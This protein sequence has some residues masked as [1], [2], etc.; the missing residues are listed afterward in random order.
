MRAAR[1]W[2]SFSGA[3]RLLMVNQFGINLGFYMLMPFLADHL[4][5]GLGLAGALVGMVLGARNLS[6]Q[7]MFL[8]GGT[9]ADRLGPKPLI[10]AGCLL[11]TVGF[12]LLGLV[13]ALPALIA[14]AAA[15]GL[16]GALFN[17]AVRSYLAAESG[18]RRVEAFAAFNVFYQA[19]ILAGPVVGLALTTV[20]FRLTCLVAAA[21]FAVLTVAQLA[22]LPH[23][24]P[25]PADRRPLRDTWRH[26]LGDRAFLGFSTAMCGAYLLS[27]QTYLAL[28]LALRA[29]DPTGSR[30][31]VAVTGMFAAGGLL[32][33]LGQRRLTA[34]CTG[35]WGPGRSLVRGT[36]LLSAAFG[37][38]ALTGALLPGPAG[39]SLA[40]FVL[41]ALPLLATGLL[42]ALATMIT[43]PFEMDTIV[44]L[45]R[46]RLVAT[47]YGLYNTIA[48]LGI[49][50]GNLVAGTALDVSRTRGVPALPW[51]VLAA[52][53][54]AATVALHRLQRSGR[55]TP[56]APRR[57]VEAKAG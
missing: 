1:G 12:A 37:L 33:V 24:P 10:A 32:T 20:G 39:A 4:S 45:S 44:A 21:V 6:Q 17:P 25:A 36:A 43:F 28:P 30:S 18:A 26:V 2:A 31:A 47:H 19:G 56:P 52:T 16:A 29:A 57:P 42:I 48:G 40:A 34:W 35:R 8:L 9:L 7:G 53:G 49:T 5:H 14:G 38:P 23:R 51:L 46:G 13:D 50:L 41:A 11:R 15:T 22:V 3:A 54:A 55:L 27:F